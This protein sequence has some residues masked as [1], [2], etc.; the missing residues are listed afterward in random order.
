MYLFILVNRWTCTTQ[1]V[2]TSIETLN[3]QAKVLEIDTI[4]PIVLRTPLN[5]LGRRCIPPRPEF[6]ALSKCYLDFAT[7]SH[8]CVFGFTLRAQ[9]VSTHDPTS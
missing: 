8:A 7:G 5:A 4:L 9:S 1:Y 6:T 2:S 3:E